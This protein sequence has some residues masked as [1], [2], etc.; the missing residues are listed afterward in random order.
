MRRAARYT[1]Y[2]GEVF[3]YCSKCNGYYCYCPSISTTTSTLSETAM[4]ECYETARLIL[5]PASLL[6]PR[7]AEYYVRNPTF[8]RP[9]EPERGNILLYRR[10][11]AVTAGTGR[12]T[13]PED[14]DTVSPL[15]EG[16]TWRNR[17]HGGPQQRGP[18]AFQ[19][20]PSWAIN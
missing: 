18:G 17:R 5:S 4:A 7:L 11:T 14:R 3:F 2:T 13:R 9:F 1:D 8:L 15:P 19:S 10:W 12:R 16:Q 20:S 6:W